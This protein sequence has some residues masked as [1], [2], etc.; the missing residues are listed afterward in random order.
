M[1][2]KTAII[3]GVALIG[4][5]AVAAIGVLGFN[6]FLGETQAPS[7]PLTSVPVIANTEPP[8][9]TPTEAQAE[10]PAQATEPAAATEASA[11]S[12]SLVV[13]EIRPE[14]SEV[15]FQIYEELGGEPKTVVGT[16]SDV[17]GQVAI[18]LGDLSKT[19][20]GVIQVNARTFV[21]D[22]NNRNRMIQNRILETGQYEL[23]TFTPTAITGLSGAAEPGQPFTFEIAGDLTIRDITQPVVFTATVQGDS[24]SQLTGTATTI[25]KRGDYNLIIPSVPN[26][27]NVGEEVTLEINFVAEAA[28]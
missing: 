14:Q 4:L 23:I 8:V 28:S 21:T 15:S 6:L 1:Q 11:T 5:L 2:N 25:V 18:D 26:V 9:Q 17:A 24:E 20:V 7:A 10:V 3:A 22:S 27:A 19:Q 13:F 12:S 16:T